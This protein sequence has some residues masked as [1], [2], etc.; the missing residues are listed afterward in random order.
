[1][2][3]IIE[4][5]DIPLWRLFAITLQAAAMVAIVALTPRVSARSNISQAHL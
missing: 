4:A 3:D 2:Q 5:D 1:M